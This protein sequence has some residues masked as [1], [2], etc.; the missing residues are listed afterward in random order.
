MVSELESSIL[1]LFNEAKDCEN[2][3]RIL[4]EKKLKSVN[5]FISGNKQLFIESLC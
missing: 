2:I 5:I 3:D 1:E 4:N